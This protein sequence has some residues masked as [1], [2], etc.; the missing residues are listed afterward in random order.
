[1]APFAARAH[2]VGDRL[3]RRDWRATAMG[4]HP[5]D[6]YPGAAS[7]IHVDLEAIDLARFVH[8]VQELRRHVAVGDHRATG[9]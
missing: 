4:R 5:P 6:F 3:Q 9:D 1:M 8:R 7:V 2:T